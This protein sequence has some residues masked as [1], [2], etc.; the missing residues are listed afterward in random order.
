[1][2][3]DAGVIYRERRLMCCEHFEKDQYIYDGPYVEHFVSIAW[4]VLVSP[5]EASDM[6]FAFVNRFIE[7]FEK[8]PACIG[9]SFAGTQ[10]R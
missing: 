5:R 6:S 3:D 4:R 7:R 9:F 2:L 10:R 1:M 8:I